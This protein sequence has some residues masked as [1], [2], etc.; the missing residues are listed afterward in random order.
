M[1]FLTNLVPEDE[2]KDGKN[3][4]VDPRSLVSEAAKLV[5]DTTAE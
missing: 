1:S 4:N 3:E 2:D 5:S